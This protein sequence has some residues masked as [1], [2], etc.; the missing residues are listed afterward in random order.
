M[1]LLVYFPQQLWE[2]LLVCPWLC[3]VGEAGPG[4]ELGSPEDGDTA[5]QSICRSG[6]AVP[7]PGQRAWLHSQPLPQTIG[8]KVNLSAALPA[9]SE[10]TP[11]GEGVSGP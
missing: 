8:T 11:W 1:W 10:A 9:A 5:L 2:L 6:K 7:A 4:Q 3:V